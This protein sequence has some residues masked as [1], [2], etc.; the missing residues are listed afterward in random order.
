[1]YD[2]YWDTSAEYFFGWGNYKYL[3]NDPNFIKSITNTLFMMMGIPIGM[4]ISFF[5][6]TILNSKYSKLKRPYLIIY[7]LPAVS[8]A[9]AIGLVWK[10]LF[11]ADYGLINKLFNT[12]I[13]WLSSPDVVKLTLMMKGVWG[14]IGGTLLLY[15]A[16]LQNIPTDLY[17]SA[18]VAG[19]NLWQKTFKITIPLVKGTSFYIMVTGIIGGL[20]AFG[21]NYIIASGTSANTIVYYLYTEFQKGNYG[22][23]TA[24]SIIVFIALFIVTLF[25][26]YLN[27]RGKKA[28]R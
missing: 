4:I 12:D 24:G 27:Y 8:S 14:G 25:Q 22:Y 23:V 7:Y 6:A 26:F 1:M 10:W 21:D 15:Y 2:F 11:N 20:M 5:L 28:V 13:S 9:I 18:D 16:S 3:F 17:E 19:A